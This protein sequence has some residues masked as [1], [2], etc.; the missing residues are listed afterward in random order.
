M[1]LGVRYGDDLVII[2]RF[3]IWPKP[4]SRCECFISS[5]NNIRSLCINIVPA[6]YDEEKAALD[7][8]KQKLQDIIDACKL[9]YDN[10]DDKRREVRNIFASGTIHS[11]HKM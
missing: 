1:K 9:L 6:K 8:H 4:H 2:G 5:K 3:Y 10:F 7:G 11:L